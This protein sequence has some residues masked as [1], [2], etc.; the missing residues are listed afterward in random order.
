MYA[1]FYRGGFDDAPD[2]SPAPVANGVS[3]AV[4]YRSQEDP[5][6]RHY[7]NDCGPA[8][9]GMLIEWAGLPALPT[10][11]LSAETSLAQHDDG[12]ACWSLAAL[13]RRHGVNMQTA[14]ALT[15]D[16]VKAEL[17]AGKPL[18]A[19]ISYSYIKE[20]QNQA[21]GA[22]HFVVV[23]GYD[24]EHVYINDPDFWTA[25]RNRGENFAVPAAEF[26]NAIKYSPSRY[27]GVVIRS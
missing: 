1:A 7:R 20:R 6:A 3:L 12:L 10:D 24:A 5:D 27:T 17:D 2:N 9:V 4:P 15:L 14:S 23:R 25:Q 22:G 13:A 8:C 26:E 21:D 19:L 16:A 18:I 11:A